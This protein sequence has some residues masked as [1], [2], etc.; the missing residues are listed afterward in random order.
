MMMIFVFLCLLF[1]SAL[2]LTLAIID[3]RVWL[4]PNVYNAALAVI[5][6]CFHAIT[7]FAI[8]SPLNMA[9]GAMLGGGLLYA[10]RF[11]ANRIYNQDTLGL[12]DVKLLAAAGIWLGPQDVLFALTL[13][14]MSGVLHGIGFVAYQY[15]KTKHIISLS[16]L[17]I[18]AGPGFCLGIFIAGVVKFAPFVQ[19]LFL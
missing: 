11:V 10:I 3:L 17:S 14:A 18:P 4:L 12:G 2:L 5:G 7:Q 13:G 6:L 9:A 15:I 1:A 8:V 16:H 19:S